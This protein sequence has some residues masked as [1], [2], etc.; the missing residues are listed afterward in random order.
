MNL[1]R[2]S[3][4]DELTARQILT[5]AGH[6]APAERKPMRCIFHAEKRPSLSILDRGYRCFSCG[7]HGGLLDLRDCRRFWLRPPECCARVRGATSWLRLRLPLWRKQ[8]AFPLTFLPRWQRMTSAASSTRI[9]L[10][11]LSRAFSRSA[12]TRIVAAVD[13]GK[14]RRQ[15]CAVRV[16][17][18]RHYRSKAVP[19][20]TIAEGDTDTVTAW[21]HKIPAIGLP[22]ASMPFAVDSRSRRGLSGSASCSRQRYAGRVRGFR[23]CSPPAFDRL[24]RTHS[25]PKPRAS[26]RPERDAPRVEQQ[27]RQRMG[28]TCCG[29][30]GD[31]R[32]H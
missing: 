10:R 8:R 13:V 27:L 30:L 31:Y 24:R 9:S 28:A 21:L 12:Q 17:T 18:C 22:G 14:R 32:F 19:A 6:L 1:D 11:W 20:L 29:S 23:R 2:P 4:I 5:L 3:I 7:A 25:P 15:D 16:T 26:Q